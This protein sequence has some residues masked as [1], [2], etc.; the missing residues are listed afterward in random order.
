[1]I[2]FAGSYTQ[3]VGP[4]LS[5]VGKGIYTY[6]L[7]DDSGELKLIDTFES[8]NTSY[9]S[10]SENKKLL[11]SFQEVSL[12][13]AP[14]VLAF[15]IKDDYS[16]VLINEQSI[17]GGLPCHL[18]L[19]KND[20]LLAV[21]CY[22]TGSIH[23]FNI[24]QNG[25][26]QKS[27]QDIIHQGK[28]VNNNRQ[29]SPHTHMIAK[30]NKEIFVPDLGIDAIVNYKLIDSNLK[31]SYKI[32]MPLGVGPR[33]IVFHKSG[34][35]GFVMNELTGEVSVLWKRKGAFYVA[36]SI[37]SLPSNFVDIP[38]GAAIQ[39]SPDGDFLYV[40]NRGSNTITIFKFDFKI[41]EL[42]IIGYQKTF[43][44]T[45]REFT[46]SPNGKWLIVANQDSN[47]LVVFERNL[48][49]GSLKKVSNNTEAKSVV[50][51]QWL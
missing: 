26:L 42:A 31:E 8:R 28:S 17:K 44:E 50:C 39:M 21:A 20:K 51:L 16:L 4:G 1:M 43:G 32:K 19:I 34:K 48:V 40:S 36:K 2:L 38:S 12:D 13:K 46:I 9:I 11:Y 24:K 37:N 15:Q 25:G 23:L 10:I 29:E 5:G 27:H 45:P 41:G 7:N 14:V 30:N 6:F 49:S 47:N 22:E 18:S 3:E 33:H 35:Y